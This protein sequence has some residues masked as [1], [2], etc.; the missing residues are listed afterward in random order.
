M[1]SLSPLFRFSPIF[2]AAALSAAAQPALELPRQSP[3][4]SVSQTFAYTTVSVEYSRPA[5]NDRVIW[6]GVVPY[7]QVWRAGANEPTLV[8]FSR[9]V[10]VEGK[11]LAAGAYALF[12]LPEKKNGGDAWTFIFSRNTKGWGAYGY[13]AKDDA[14]RVTVAPEKA[15]HEERM[16]FSFD[17]VTDD[18]VALTLHWGT[19]AGRVAIAAEFVETAKANIAAWRAGATDDSPFP[20]LHAAR[21]TWT[22]ASGEEERAEALEWVDRSIAVRP[23]FVNLWAKAE[24]LASAGRHAEAVETGT[25]ARA[26]AAEDPGFASR[27]PDIDK[28]LKEWKRKK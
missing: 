24:M 16:A 23:L 21:F 28:T 10:T 14:L 25:R 19:L 18:G 15:L 26:A 27:L 5:V 17:K 9:D 1:K 3:A 13:D 11:P 22:H 4:A 12:V 8:E 2:L 6:G 20:W 7:D